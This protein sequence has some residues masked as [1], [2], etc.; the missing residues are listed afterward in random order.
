LARIVG[1]AAMMAVPL[2]PMA[3]VATQEDQSTALTPVRV[4]VAGC[5]DDAFMRLDLDGGTA[6]C[7]GRIWR[8][9]TICRAHDAGPRS[10][11]DAAGRPWLT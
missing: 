3:S 10:I 6:L 9:S 1:N 2:T 5:S 11:L 8:Q 7:Q 4:S